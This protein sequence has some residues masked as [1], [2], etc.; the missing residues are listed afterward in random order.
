MGT[1]QGAQPREET[2][3]QKMK[4]YMYTTCSAL[5]PRRKSNVVSCASA[6]EMV[7]VRQQCDVRQLELC[8]DVHRSGYDTVWREM[9]CALLTRVR[10]ERTYELVTN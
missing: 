4:G 1:V 2:A 3:Q 5:A 8:T 9:G 7:V 10:Q 6:D